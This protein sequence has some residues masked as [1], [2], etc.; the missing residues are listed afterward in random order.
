MLTVLEMQ[1]KLTSDHW[2]KSLKNSMTFRLKI[3]TEAKTDF[4]PR[5]ASRPRRCPRGQ[6]HCKHVHNEQGRD[7][8]SRFSTAQ[9]RNRHVDWHYTL[10]DHT[11]FIRC[12]LTK[13]SQTET[14]DTNSTRKQRHGHTDFFQLTDFFVPNSW[15]SADKF[16]MVCEYFSIS[17]NRPNVSKIQTSQ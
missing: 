11:L 7:P 15:Q 5:G 16:A 3:K 12:G 14:K 9:P 13:N 2:R 8:F 1:N 17:E 10:R 6:H 4:C